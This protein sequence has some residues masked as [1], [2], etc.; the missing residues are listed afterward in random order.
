MLGNQ[1]Y[2]FTNA[3]KNGHQS[4]NIKIQTVSL[5]VI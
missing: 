1:T 3:I 5:A 2:S 4:D